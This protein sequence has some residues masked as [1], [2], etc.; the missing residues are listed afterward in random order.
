[1]ETFFSPEDEFIYDLV[2]EYYDNP[3]MYFVK[4]D[5]QYSI[6]GIQIPSLLMNAKR[7]LLATVPASVDESTKNLRELSWSTF[8]I[9]TLTDSSIY[10]N[11]PIA[12]YRQKRNP[13]YNFTLQV[14]KRDKRVTTYQTPYKLTVSLLHVKGLEYE[15][16][17]EGTFISALETFQTLLIL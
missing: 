14:E 17:N 2:A 16:P 15:Y 3:K 9:R 8:Q 13:K 11:L 12:N 10:H 4:K 6:Y 7:F 5:K 1:M